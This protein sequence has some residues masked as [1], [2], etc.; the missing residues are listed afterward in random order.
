MTC[1]TNQ[2]VV[3]IQLSLVALMQKKDAFAVRAMQAVIPVR[4][5]LLVDDIQH[6]CYSR[7]PRDG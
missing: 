5:P 1:E 2:V 3:V 4:Q 6:P 7:Y